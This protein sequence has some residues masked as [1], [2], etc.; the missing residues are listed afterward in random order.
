MVTTRK[1]TISREDR[2]CV[3]RSFRAGLHDLRPNSRDNLRSIV[4]VLTVV[5]VA[6]DLPQIFLEVP[7]GE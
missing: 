7:I 5:P 2:L 3:K 6:I 4:F 1:V